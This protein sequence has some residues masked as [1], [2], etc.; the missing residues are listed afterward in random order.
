MR[1]PSIGRW[2]RP[3]RHSRAR[4]IATHESG[5]RATE[6]SSLQHVVDLPAARTA[7]GSG[8]AAISD[9]VHGSRPA[10]DDGF[11]LG[12]GGDAAEANE[13][14]MD[15]DLKIEVKSNPVKKI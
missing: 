8:A 12:I 3:Y 6:A 11:D 7:A 2:A 5:P 13:H 15:L 14:S 10:G 4:A 9:L 1:L